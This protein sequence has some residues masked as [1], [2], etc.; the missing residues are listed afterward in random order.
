MNCRHNKLVDEGI[1][2]E[3]FS[4]EDLQV[5]VH[6]S[7]NPIVYMILSKC[8]SVNLFWAVVI[9]NVLNRKVLVPVVDEK[10]VFFEVH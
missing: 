3:V 10:Y 2:Q 5:V 6:I 9:V 7:M 4:L 8:V 1:P